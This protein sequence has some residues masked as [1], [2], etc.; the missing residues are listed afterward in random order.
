[1]RRTLT[2][3]AAVVP[4]GVVLS[5]SAIPA[6][7][8]TLVEISAV[9][10][11]VIPGQYIVTL[12]SD[13]GASVAATAGVTPQFVYHAALTGFAAKLNAAQLKA[14]QHNPNVVAIEPDQVA[15]ALTTQSPAPSWG[16]DRIDQRNRP[17]N[18]A[19][20]FNRTGSGV[21]A[22]VIDT[23]ITLNHPDFGGRASFGFD[24]FGGNGVD[25]HGHGT[26]VA[27]TIGGARFGVA[28]GVLLKAVRVLNCSGSGSFSGII[29]GIDWVRLNSP[30]KAVANM[31]LGGGFSSSVNNATAN[32]ANSGVT[33]AVAAGNSAANACN[34]SPAS[35]PQAVTAAASDINDRSAS[36]T[37]FGSCVDLYAPG[38]SIT[39]DW[40]NGGTNTI[41]GT[42]MASPHVAGVAALYKSSVSGDPSS[43]TVQS[44]LNSNATPGV[45]SAVPAGTP[46]RLLFTAG[47]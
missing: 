26:H 21:T 3:L 47:L 8:S 27:G 20:T 16:L 11:Q 36:F 44:F 17:L 40:L 28:K 15:H 22:Y 4:L 12:K 6:E 46:N 5:L 42:S 10:G 33:I 43:A 7:A 23:G 32:L 13:Q 9:N 1:M 25:C 2:A 24:A 35:T 29:A 45:I 19:Y 14:M 18:N 37:N 31:S 39:S 30:G 41:S 38:V 34:F